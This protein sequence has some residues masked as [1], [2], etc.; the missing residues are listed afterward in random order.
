VNQTL[1][2]RAEL[3]NSDKDSMFSLM[4]AHFEGITR[5]QF[6]NDLEEK[7]WVVL[8]RRENEIVGFSTILAKP[9]TVAGESLLTIYSGDTIVA[10][11]AWQSFA[12]PRA[13]IRSIYSLPEQMPQ[14]RLIWIL[15]TSGFRTY[16]FLPVFWKE[17]YPQAGVETPPARQSLMHELAQR[18]YGRFFNPEDGV[19][20]FQHPQRLRGSLQ[21]VPPGRTDDPDIAFFL[22]QN[23]GHA[24]GDEL[25]CIADLSPHNLT[26]AGRRIVY[27]N[28]R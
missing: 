28:V 2:Q 27:G 26:P 9:M 24:R 21:T 22:S 23:P 8:V 4:D 16:R 14:R 6:E 17:F 3:T 15:L 1:F 12:F 10:P 13:W 20:R 5:R 11:S 25:V 19:V 7:N 18:Q